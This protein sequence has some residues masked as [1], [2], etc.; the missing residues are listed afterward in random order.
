MTN[1]LIFSTAGIEQFRLGTK[2]PSMQLHVT[3]K[4]DD[5]ILD[6]ARQLATQPCMKP[7]TRYDL[8]VPEDTHWEL[9]K[10]A[11]D[12][13]MHHED[14]AQNVLIG[15]VEHELDRKAKDRGD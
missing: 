11:A 2:C 8:E 9:V 1:D 7:N 6:Y 12:L 3:S 5:D 13:K 15:H 4:D 14:Y 10:L